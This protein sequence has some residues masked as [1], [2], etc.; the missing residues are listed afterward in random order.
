MTYDDILKYYANAGKANPMLYRPDQMARDLGFSGTTRTQTG[1][2]GSPSES[3]GQGTEAIY[4]LTPDFE[5][6]LKGY[7]YEPAT[8]GGRNA[9]LDIRDSSGKM[10]HDDYRVG[11]HKGSAMKIAGAVIPALVAGGFGAGIGG[12]MG[13]G[14]MAGVGAPGAGPAIGNGAFLGEGVASGIPAWDAAAAGVQSYGVPTTGMEAFR[15]LATEPDAWSKTLSDSFGGAGVENVGA[16]AGDVAAGNG[17]F[18]GE[19]PWT[20]T[21]AGPEIGNGAFLGESPWTPTAAGPPIGNGEFLGESPW[22]P[23]AAAG[24]AAAGAAE[25]GTTGLDAMRAGE[26]ANYATDGS[27]PSSAAVANGIGGIP[28]ADIVG[29]LAGPLLSTGA[30]LYGANQAS[31]AMQ[32]ATTQANDL[33]RY[34]YDTTRADNAPALAARNSALT[35]MQALLKDP[36]SLTSQ[37]GYQF[38]LNEGTKTLNSGAAA[39]GMTYSGAQ[40]KALQRF[41]QDYAGTKLDASFNRLSS[42]A[43]GGAQGAWQTGTA[44]ANYGNNVGNNLTNQGNAN[45]MPYMIGANAFGDAVNGLSAYGNRAGWWGS[46]P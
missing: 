11:D 32:A 8:S 44:A 7:S 29:A 33:Q 16:A 6:F 1:W 22:T 24:A 12:L 31:N 28:W 45:A 35:Q 25:L 20:P 37:P 46:K 40:G 42:L 9:A 43:N 19:A 15:S 26:I 30:Q 4:D 13:Y 14:P 2:G 23:T 39:R 34:T 27:L 3:T 17:A 36:S 38:G 21:A 41:G 10:V 5:Q 18:L